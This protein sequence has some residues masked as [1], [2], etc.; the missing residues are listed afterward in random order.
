MIF[1]LVPGIAKSRNCSVVSHINHAADSI[2]R[3]CQTTNNPTNVISTFNIGLVIYLEL[4]IRIANL[5]IYSRTDNPTNFMRLSSD[6][7][8]VISLSF[9]N[10]KFGTPCNSTNRRSTCH[11][12]YIDQTRHNSLIGWRLFIVNTT[13]DTAYIIN[14]RDVSRIDNIFNN[15][16]SGWSNNWPNI[17][18]SRHG[19]GNNIHIAYIGTIIHRTEKSDII[20]VVSFDGEAEYI[21]SQPVKAPWKILNWGKSF[22]IPVPVTG[23]R[24]K[25]RIN[26]ISQS[27][28]TADICGNILKLEQISNPHITVCGCLCWSIHNNWKLFLFC[29]CVGWLF[30]I[31]GRIPQN[32]IIFICCLNYQMIRFRGCFQLVFR[33]CIQ[34]IGIDNHT[35]SIKRHFLLWRNDRPHTH[36]FRSPCRLNSDRVNY[37]LCRL[38][39]REL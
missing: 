30:F 29:I 1:V 18:V 3:W 15:N 33:I 12:T 8:K 5:N 35:I 21:I 7:A 10:S 13:N 24:G 36:K 20:Y 32:N 23:I 2:I 39:F 37:V 4:I 27:I 34:A 28:P 9:D 22:S 16:W 25:I 11:R 26:G 17:F 31:V 6:S 38:I 14:T 19:S